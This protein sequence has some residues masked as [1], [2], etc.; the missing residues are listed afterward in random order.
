MLLSAIY[1]QG[2]LAG[3]GGGGGTEFLPHIL[4]L[5]LSIFSQMLAFA[6]QERQFTLLEGINIC[7]K[8]HDL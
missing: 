2:I 3:G 7:C 6:V 1:L 5:A 8:S 4:R